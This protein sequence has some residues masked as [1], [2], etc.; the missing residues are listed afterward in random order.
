MIVG[1]YLLALAFGV[2]F[3]G[4][5]LGEFVFTDH[6]FPALLHLSSVLWDNQVLYQQEAGYK[7]SG[8]SPYLRQRPHLFCQLL[9]AGIIVWD[10]ES[11]VI[12]EFLTFFSE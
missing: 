1:L 12:V 9:I 7:L 8:Q 11:L 4:I 5:C 10:F 3:G 2:Y 6:T